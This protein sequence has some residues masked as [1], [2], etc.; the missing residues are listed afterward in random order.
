MS[1]LPT[2]VTAAA[3]GV[4]L[5][6]S[7][8]SPTDQ[9]STRALTTGPVPGGDGTVARMALPGGPLGIAVAPEGFAYIT[10]GYF[11]QAPGTVARVDLNARTVTATIPVGMVPSLVIFN[12]TRTRAYVSNQWSDNVGIIDVA[13]NT[14][15]DAIPT[16][17]DPFALALSPDGTT[18]LVTTNANSLF[19]FDIATKAVL[20]SIALPATSHHII[21]DP[22]GK[23]LYVAT[24]DGGTVMEVD[25][26]AMT[27]NRTF[28]LGGRPQDMAF[29]PDGE[30]L[31]VANE[32]SNVLHVIKRAGGTITNV[33]LAGGGEG[34]AVGNNGAHLYVGLVFSGAVQ[35]IDRPHLTTV[36]V[37][38]VGGVPREI[39]LD[40]NGRDVLVSND[41]GWIDFIEPSDSLPPPPDFARVALAGGPIGIATF[42]NSALVSQDQ[43]GTVGRLDLTSST[44]TNSIVTGGVPAYLTFNGSGSTAYVANFTNHNVGII[45]VATNTQ[46]GVIPVNADPLPVAISHDGARLFVTTD[47]NRLYKIDL[48]TNAVVDSLGLPATSHHLLTHPNDALVYVATRD[49]GTV[50]EVNQL[51][52]AVVR[53]FTLGGRPQG[54]A[55]SADGAVLYVANELSNV[56]HIITLSSGATTNVPLTSGGEGMALGSDGKL[57]IGEVF[58][59]LVEVVDPVTRTVVRTINTGGT[60][61]EVAADAARNQ[62]LVANEAGWVDLVHIH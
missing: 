62:V 16:T 42:S 43:A 19:K 33:P 12:P 4:A 13:S 58:A 30:E 27:V 23:Y 52:M 55:L 41:G 28:A 45:D 46:T 49:A 29:S 54:M 39:A 2:T 15:I 32:L 40:Y 56:L 22:K 11:G 50:L 47:V 61:R 38:P 37:I 10:Q 21:M 35:V 3:I 5:A 8:S 18:L 25:W 59:G 51:T 57:Y 60:P 9:N 53:T 20:G 17:G 26:Q 31:Y 6:F 14:Q 1:R 24:R 36:R 7:C 48:S 44:F 34:L